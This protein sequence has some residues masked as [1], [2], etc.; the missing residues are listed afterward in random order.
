MRQ[1]SDAILSIYKASKNSTQTQFLMYAFRTISEYVPF[2]RLRWR[3]GVMGDTG[4]VIQT[5]GS[6]AWPHTPAGDRI[7]TGTPGEGNGF[8]RLPQIDGA[9]AEDALEGYEFEH[10]PNTIAVWYRFA[11]HELASV[12]GLDLRFAKLSFLVL[13]LHRESVARSFTD[14]EREVVQTLH[15]HISEAWATNTS[16]GLQRF[17]YAQHE[18]D[19]AG[20]IVTADGIFLFGDERFLRHLAERWP[21]PVDARL[22]DPLRLALAADKTRHVENA[23]GYAIMR[24]GT[25][26][27]ICMHPRRAVDSLTARELQV[28]QKVASGLTHK[29]IARLF[30]VSP[31]TVRKQIVSIHERMGVRNN[32]ELAAQL[33]PGLSP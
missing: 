27:Y 10:R 25:I 26:A 17:L 3:A 30:G 23:H 14:N 11:E 5:L 21:R 19:R 1:L 24:E 20:A 2:N 7:A 18:R 12:E 4:L 8:T 32:A 15:T 22:P 29:E 28:A 6:L 9:L 33:G 31:S 13:S 16:D